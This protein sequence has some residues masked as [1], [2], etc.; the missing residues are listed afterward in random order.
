MTSPRAARR[1]RQP[2][3]AAARCR[4]RAP[5]TRPAPR[6]RDGKERALFP[7]ASGKGWSREGPGHGAGSRAEPAKAPVGSEETPTSGGRRGPRSGAWVRGRPGAVKGTPSRER[8]RPV[9]GAGCPRGVRGGGCGRA[10]GRWASGPGRGR[11]RARRGRDRPRLL[12]A[13]RRSRRSRRDCPR[14]AGCRDLINFGFVAQ[15]ETRASE[16]SSHGV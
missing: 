9:A 7:P 8:P 12:R 11:G 3:R 13:P 10:G 5:T 2:S 4:K 1:C 15:P 14:R 16:L 6:T